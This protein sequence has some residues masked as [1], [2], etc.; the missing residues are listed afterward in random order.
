MLKL[1]SI[2]KDFAKLSAILTNFIVRKSHTEPPLR[3]DIVRR[4]ESNAGSYQ[5]SISTESWSFA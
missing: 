3:G 2:Y 4:G 1:D 5:S